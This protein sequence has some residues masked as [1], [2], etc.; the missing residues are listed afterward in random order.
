MDADKLF[1]TRCRQITS[2]LELHNE[3]D[4]LDLS[5]H[6]R[7][8]LVDQQALVDT[9]NA[10]AGKLKLEFRVGTFSREP[11]QFT[12][13]LSLEDR[14]DPETM[15]L[16]GRAVVLSQAAFLSHVVMYASGQSLTV[17]EL[18]K[19]AAESAGGVHY[20]PHSAKHRVL[21]QLSRRLGIGGL[22]L[23]IRM[24]KAVARVT[25]RGLNPLIER[26][27]KKA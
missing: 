25:M 9:V 19:H 1:L 4:L 27:E 17:R 3:I 13:L 18:I 6:L 11:D 23:G 20:N 7:Q 10:R 26:V 12:A 15:R 21:A 24:L 16:P 22:P 8:L 2:L 5:G 14:L